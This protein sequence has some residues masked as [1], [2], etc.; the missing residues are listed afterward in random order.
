MVDLSCLLQETKKMKSIVSVYKLPWNSSYSSDREE[1]YKDRE[2][3]ISYLSELRGEAAA[4]EAF[5]LTNAPTEYLTESQQEML[6]ALDFKGPSLSVGD[7]VRVEQYP[8]QHS[9]P[10]EYYLCKSFGWEK[11]EKDV[12]PLIKH[13][14][15]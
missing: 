12:I 3:G 2:S 8:K 7:I 14:S 11:Y 15:W 4:E 5:H 9:T 13:L 10:A 6:K 1:W